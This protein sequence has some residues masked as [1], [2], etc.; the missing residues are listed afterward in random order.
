VFATMPRAPSGTIEA[1]R[2]AQSVLA[3]GVALGFACSPPDGEDLYAPLA[4]SGG[5]PGASGASGSAG[6]SGNAGFPGISGAAG[7]AGAPGSGGVG[8]SA[9]NGGA[10]GQGGAS[11]AGAG[12]FAGQG[13]VD[14]GVDSGSSACVP[15]AELCNGLDDDC[16]GVVD[17]PGTCDDGCQAFLVDGRSY[18]FCADAVAPGVAR[19]R[20]AGAQ[21][22]LTWIET[23]EENAALVQAL[24]ELGV[25]SGG[26]EFLV[27]L[28]ASDADQ[29]QSWFWVD[30]AVVSGGF[31]FWEGAGA[32]DGGE[33]VDGAYQNWGDGEPN[34]DND[35]EDCAVLSVLGSEDRDPGQWDDRSCDAGAAFV[36]EAP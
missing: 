27:Q 2:F 12:G 25:A 15:A 7:S 6:A 30:N 17:P 14:A 28:G 35:G 10:A 32:D 3:L 9:G 13:P 8:G 16:D 11:G 26:E 21:M 23:P 36:C 34:D 29:E 24:V 20:C 18:M 1:R 31:Q 19:G 22:N 4:G 5:A 33:P